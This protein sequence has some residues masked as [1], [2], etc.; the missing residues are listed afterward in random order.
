ML[1][2]FG[3]FLPDEGHLD[4]GDGAFVELPL[5][6]VVLNIA[7]YIGVLF[8]RIIVGARVAGRPALAW[9]VRRVRF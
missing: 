5:H 1:G 8:Q 4:E 3:D 2:L 6:A 9:R 7:V